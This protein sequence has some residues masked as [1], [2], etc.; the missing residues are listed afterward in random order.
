MRATSIRHRLGGAVLAGPT[1]L[2][3]T[4][5]SLGVAQAD[6][7][8]YKKG[9]GSVV[10]TDNLAELPAERRS[11]YNQQKAEREARRRELEARVGKDELARQ[12]AETAKAELAKQQLEE[13]VRRERLARIDAQLRERTER[14]KVTEADKAK[15]QGR[16]RGARAKLAQLLTDFGRAKETF[17]SLG[18]R[19]SHTL[20]PGQ[21]EE[22]ER[23]RAQVAQLETEIDAT[24]L[25][26]EET[27]PEEARVAGVPPGWIRD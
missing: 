23:A 2:L 27:I 19:A 17:E 13:S 25:E 3:S 10:Y 11:Y 24:V 21:A 26:I 6:T 20:L 18:T 9:D 22:L 7:Y 8:K 16:M 5:L 1:A 14:R 12:E 15:W 4:L